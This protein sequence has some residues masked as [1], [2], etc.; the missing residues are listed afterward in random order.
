MTHRH[1][2]A[3]AD[4]L[5]EDRRLVELRCLCVADGYMCNSP[6]LAAALKDFGHRVGRGRVEA[7]LVWLEERGLVTLARDNLF[8]AR[9]TAVGEAVAEG[10]E[11]ADGVRRP[12]PGE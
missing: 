6:V 10:L 4:V 2:R 7:D 8:T 12:G 11:R 1:S 9:I 3:L 5:A